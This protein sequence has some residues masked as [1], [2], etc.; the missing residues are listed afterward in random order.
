MVR[1]GVGGH[2]L[3]VRVRADARAKPSPNA[4]CV[5]GRADT[6]AGRVSID[7]R[8]YPIGYNGLVTSPHQIL[9]QAREAAGMS[10]DAL[11]RR[12]HTSRS[13]LSAYEHG[14]KSPTLSVAARLVSAAGFNISLDRRIEFEQQATARG[15]PVMV[16][17]RLPRLSLDEAFRTVDLPMHLN[18]SRSTARYDMTDRRQRSRVYE[19]VLREGTPDDV[20]TYIDGA[21]LVDLWEDLVLPTEIRRAW[22]PA[23]TAALTASKRV[24]G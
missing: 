6:L 16:P 5:R 10:Q 17:T 11:A 15:R 4:A 12:A 9:I 20:L 24:G 2:A 13:T 22:E 7:Q 21:L 8:A 23:I 1:M 14:Y 3:I 18:W 19:M